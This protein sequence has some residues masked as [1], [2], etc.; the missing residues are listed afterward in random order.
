MKKR[1]LD[2]NPKRQTLEHGVM[3][4]VLKLKTTFNIL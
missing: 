3:D 2:V 1:L 4:I